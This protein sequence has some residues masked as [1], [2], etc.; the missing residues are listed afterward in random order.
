MSLSALYLNGSGVIG[1]RGRK[2]YRRGRA[3]FC[4]TVI[5]APDLLPVV[6]LRDHFERVTAMSGPHREALLRTPTVSSC[7]ITTLPWLSRR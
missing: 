5:V 3:S 7:W 6:R 1:R 4:I 2:A